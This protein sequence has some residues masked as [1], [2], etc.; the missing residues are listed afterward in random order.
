MQA[1][2]LIAQGTTYTLTPRTGDPLGNVQSYQCSGGA[3]D[4]PSTVAPKR[5]TA[6]GGPVPASVASSPVP[7]TQAGAAPPPPP[8]RP[9][10][11]TTP[12]NRPA[13]RRS[14]RHFCTLGTREVPFAPEPGRFRASE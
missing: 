11:V 5:C 2:G 10:Q 3:A 13:P 14:E 7:F 1:T 9:T 6:V 4:T 12:L 8:P